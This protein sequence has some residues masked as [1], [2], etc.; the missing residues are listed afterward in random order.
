FALYLFGGLS[1]IIVLISGF[2]G[3]LLS[4]WH[5]RKRPLMILLELFWSFCKIG[6][7]SFGGLVW[8][9]SSIVKCCPTAG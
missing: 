8:S 3:W 6:F 1:C 7:T 9:P 5:C 4:V 2:L